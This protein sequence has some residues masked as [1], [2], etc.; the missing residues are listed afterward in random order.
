MGDRLAHLPGLT[1]QP[2]LRSEGHRQLENELAFAIENMDPDDS[3]EG[4]K[5]VSRLLL[6]IMVS[7]GYW[8]LGTSCRVTKSN[9]VKT[10]F[11]GEK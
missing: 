4:R 1:P 2:S 9:K 8:P 7:R 3:K 11:P 6:K 10:V 5:A